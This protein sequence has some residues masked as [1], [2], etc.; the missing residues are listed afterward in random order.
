MSAWHAEA[1]PSHY[2]PSNLSE[3]LRSTNVGIDR[4]VDKNLES[5]VANNV[6]RRTAFWLSDRRAPVQGSAFAGHHMTPVAT[7]VIPIK[8]S[9]SNFT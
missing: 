2:R 8:A 9:T 4:G 3:W 6:A 7:P 5:D 1:N